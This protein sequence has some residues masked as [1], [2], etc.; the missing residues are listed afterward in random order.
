MAERTRHLRS[1][2]ESE[3]GQ[4]L[5]T[6]RRER[7]LSLNDVAS[8]TGISPSFI[9]HIEN[10]RSD[11]TIG[12]LLRLAGFYDVDVSK[13]LPVEPEVE[14]H[15]IRAGH[16]TV[17]HSSAE[18][19]DVFLLAPDLQHN[20]MP[21]LTVY[22]EGG[23]TNDF[24]SSKGENLLYVLEGEVT[25]DFEDG[26]QIILRTGDT[27]YYRT[28]RPHTFANAGA[29]RARLLSCAAL[30]ATTSAHGTGETRPGT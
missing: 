13:L 11:I 30:D 23:K 7:R 9:S 4:R 6:L 25:V 14:P 5:R 15:V 17:L 28:D 21:C 18:G 2:F 1:G 29:G 12:R 22:Q 27:A 20:M 19:L 26:E 10:G 3:L 16:H 24:F 8:A